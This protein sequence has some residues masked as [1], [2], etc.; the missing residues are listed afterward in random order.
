MSRV[1]S[2]V[3]SWTETLLDCGVDVV[4]RTRYCIHPAERVADIPVLGGTKRLE[5][6]QWRHLEADLV[7]MDRDEN[8][9]EIAD[10]CPFPRFTSHVRSLADAAHDTQRLGE[11]LDNHPLQQVAQR[12]H[13]VISQP[14]PDRP[15]AAIPG[16]LHWLH[17]P[18]SEPQTL[19]Y[20][21]WRKPWMAAGTGTFIGAMLSHLGFGWALPPA[22]EPYPT[23]ELEAFDPKT[24]L[25]LL[26]S[27]PYPFE[28]HLTRLASL[29]YPMAL[30]DGELYSWYGVRALRFLEEALS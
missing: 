20:L 17:K 16:V 7:V 24:T 4:G 26:S 18:E 25:L 15:L 1:I 10:Q 5:W 27:E 2:L 29:P 6:S 28:R 12:W 23:I 13:R 30:V 11:Q 21:I 14:L 19:L 9:L 22:G 8:T 3:P